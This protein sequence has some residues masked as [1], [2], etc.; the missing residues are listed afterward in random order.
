MNKAYAQGERPQAGMRNAISQAQTGR[1]TRTAMLLHWLVTLFL[2]VLIGLGWYMV[3]IPRGT[4]DRG[5][6][7]NL[8]KSIGVTAAVFIAVRIAWRATH[9]PPAL[10]ASIPEWQRRAARLTH[11]LLYACIVVMPLSGFTASNFTQYGVKYFGMPLPI[12]GWE[13]KEIYT[14]FNT[15]HVYTSYLLV[16]LIALHVAAAFKHLLSD[17]NRVFQSMLPG[18]RE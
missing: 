14:V 7:F 5:Y 8:H 15:I 4:P 18:G 9:T 17:R 10:P 13:D 3:E 1:Y 6:F 16:T 11:G 12:L 2:L